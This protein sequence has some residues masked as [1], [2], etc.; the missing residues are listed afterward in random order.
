[1]SALPAPPAP[2][3]PLLSE[4]LDAAD[5]AAE[6]AAGRV[7]R[8]QHPSLPL[9]VYSY[10]P[11]CVFDNHWTDVTRRCR[12]LVADD[13]TGEL[14][15]TAFP[16]F[17]NYE[18]HQADSPYAP[19]LPDG[20][21]FEVYDK[22][23]GS[24]GI[25]FHYAGG[26]HVATKAA[27]RSEQARWAQDWLDARDTSAL[28]PGVTYLAEIVYPGNRIVVDNGSTESLVLIAVFAAD[29]TELPLPYGVAAW[30]QLGGRVVRVHQ[31][32]SLAELARLAKADRGIDG[33]PVAGTSAE[34]WVVRFASGVRVKVKLA[35]YVRLHAAVSR[36][37]ERSIWEV[38]AAGGDVA[39][40]FE[41]MPDEFRTWI[42]GV[43]G[44]L[45]AAH[46]AW[47]DAAQAAYAEIG[48][49][50]DRRSFAA[51]AAA[52]RYKE[53]KSALFLLFDG[54]PVDVLAWRAVKPPVGPPF[55]PVE[56]G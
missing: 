7:R 43:A 48:P 47:T 11:Q 21:A 34:G 29:G 23:D 50:P 51:A 31:V 5:L 1:M 17:F 38:L 37:T 14:V 32:A 44:R 33:A 52:P 20:E 35:D 28:V 45:R 13:R 16:K 3:R 2:A 49:Q 25:V 24:L 4:I 10:G 53:Y 46:D 56:P 12:G 15:A 55:R 40:L 8:T 9:S 42:L 19:E 36:T 26:W 30:R 22:V 39:E 18:Q 54:R 41:R 6:I 27:F